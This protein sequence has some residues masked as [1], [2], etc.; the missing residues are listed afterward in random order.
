MIPGHWSDDTKLC[1]TYCYST[2]KNISWQVLISNLILCRK[3]L[4]V[5]E[6]SVLKAAHE[7]MGKIGDPKPLTTD[8]KGD[9]QHQQQP[10]QNGSGPVQ[11]NV[12]GI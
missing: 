1:F 6:L 11:R 10:Q 5:L 3:V 4:I 7:V 9:Q 2:L 12:T 8:S